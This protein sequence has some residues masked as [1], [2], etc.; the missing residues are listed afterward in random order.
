MD[1]GTDTRSMSGFSQAKDHLQVT[2]SHF[3][4]DQV[5]YCPTLSDKLRSDML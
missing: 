5:A 3:V 2:E 1:S 4:T